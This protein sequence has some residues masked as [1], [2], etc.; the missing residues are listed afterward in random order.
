MLLSD[1]ARY[2]SDF[3]SFVKKEC[4]L[5]ETLLY[6]SESNHA[7]ISPYFRFNKFNLLVQ[8][9]ITSFDFYNTIALPVVLR[10]AVKNVYHTAPDEVLDYV[11]TYLELMLIEHGWDVVYQNGTLMFR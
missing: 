7:K 9:C 5:E 6:K 1:K 11:G 3:N 4:Q 2:L 10:D 8:H